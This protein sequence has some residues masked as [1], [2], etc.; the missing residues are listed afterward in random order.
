MDR[1]LSNSPPPRAAARPNLLLLLALGGSLLTL[2]GGSGVVWALWPARELPTP[3]P[4][5][6]EVG[7]EGRPD[8]G[9]KPKV[10][11]ERDAQLAEL[12]AEVLAL[13]GAL[14]QQGSLGQMEE[15]RRAEVE[16][17]L[18]RLVK[19]LDRVRGALAAER[20]RSSGLA[21]RNDA[22]ARQV[23]QLGGEVTR[24]KDDLGFTQKVLVRAAGVAAA[25]RDRGATAAW[26]GLV[27]TVQS[28][29]CDEVNR[30][31]RQK[32]CK[33]AVQA[34]LAPHEA[35]FRKCYARD[36]DARIVL[37]GEDPPEG[38][39]ALRHADVPRLKDYWVVACAPDP[40]SGAG[41]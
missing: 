15:S 9:D 33:A 18:T 10:L 4:A 28:E 2:L 14:E 23:E 37:K 26:E 30:D 1:S 39:I 6:G 12:R 25:E 35:A 36:E 13:R 11:E 31:A 5:G 8:R 3:A 29:A 40:E 27:A 21:G 7:P 17:E 41:R 22:L 38:A 34:T 20:E 19:E 32:E 16:A 24:L